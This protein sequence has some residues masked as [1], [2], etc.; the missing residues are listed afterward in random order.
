MNGFSIDVLPGAAAPVVDIKNATLRE[1]PDWMFEALGGRLSDSGERV[2]ATTALRHGP[3]WQGVNVLAGDMGQLPIQVMRVGRNGIERDAGSQIDWL[4]NDE[5]NGFQRGSQW[6]EMMVARAILWGNAV[7]AIDTVGG[8]PTRLLP[9]PPQ[10]TTYDEVRPY[11][12]VIKTRID[13]EPREF[14]PEETFHIRGLSTEG[15]WGLSFVDVAKQVVGHGL[16]L[17]KHGNSVFRNGAKPSGV[18]RHPSKMAEEARRNFREEWREHHAGAQNAGNIAVLW[19]GMEYQ[20]LSMSNEDAQ[21]LEALKLDREQVAGL[22]LLPPYK[23]GAME[24][25]AV[26]ANIEAQAREYVNQ[27]LRRWGKKFEEEAYAKLF[28]RSARKRRNTLVRVSYD[29]LTRG[30]N[31]AV[32][33]YVSEGVRARVLTRNEAREELNM[34]PVDGGDE[35]ENPAIDPATPQEDPQTT[36]SDAENQLIRQ[37]VG[38]LLARE[39]RELNTRTQKPAAFLDG[40]EGFYSHYQ[41][42]AGEY[43]G[44]ACDLLGLE[45][46][47]AATKH[48][49][50][51]MR[52]VL[53]LAGAVREDELAGAVPGL[54]DEIRGRADWLAAEILKG[55]RHG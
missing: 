48:S 12:Y 16:A 41:E 32:M 5:P 23:L 35:F 18:I 14:T 19:E 33:T 55:A 21:W 24:N 40:V 2:N 43:L 50:R 17:T 46:R 20:P 31:Q 25:S 29:V 1:P 45:W 27:S 6:K 53:D 9:L 7:C 49:Q 8:V 4:L 3:V 36:T 10:H 52:A 51:S 42:H 22:L 28:T 44:H 26:R 39:C 38:G 37:L 15:F 54:C 13:G 34:N 47:E 30:D 11:E